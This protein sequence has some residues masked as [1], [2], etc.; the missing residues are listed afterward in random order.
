MSER[1]VLCGDADALAHAA[2]TW[3]AQ[4]LQAAVAERGGATLVLAGGSTPRRLYERLA[5][6]AGSD[7]LPWAAVTVLFGDERAVGED[8]PDSNYRV[9]RE[10]LLDGL[11]TP[12]LAVHR[13]RGELGSE[14]AAREYEAHV[15]EVVDVVLLGLGEDG[16]TASLFP[17][18]PEV[19]VADRRVVAAYGP[20][21]PPERVSLSLATL[22]RARD[23]GF[24]VSGAGKADML[25]EVVASRR[26][27]RPTLPSAR[28]DPLA[29]EV[30]FFADR[31]AA[32]HLPK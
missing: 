8:D 28:V 27:G 18:R 31:D 32:T 15:P 23:A 1:I 4:R 16:H 7:G 30:V 19:E 2:A 21:P 13:M 20:K 24:L 29:G 6:T 5:T 3:V 14:A 25:A 9:A 26:A 11:A 10:A 17:G 12:P 22:N